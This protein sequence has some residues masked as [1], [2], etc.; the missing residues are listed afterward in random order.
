MLAGFVLL[1]ASGDVRRVQEMVI[2]AI[3]VALGRWLGQSGINHSY[4]VRICDNHNGQINLHAKQKYE[5]LCATY[6]CT[7]RLQIAGKYL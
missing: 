5:V 7:S 3:Y 2:A 6:I 4:W 1:L